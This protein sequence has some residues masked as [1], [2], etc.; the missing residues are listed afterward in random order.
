MVDAESLE[1]VVHKAKT[2]GEPD[3]YTEGF[4]RLIKKDWDF[5]K[6]KRAE[7]EEQAELEEEGCPP[8]DD[9]DDPDNP[10]FRS[11][12]GCE[13]RDVGWMKVAYTQVMVFFYGDRLSD[14]HHWGREY[15]RPPEIV[16]G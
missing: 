15:R 6:E 16:R 14:W 9:L 12:E 4:V 3:P 13:I 11:V 5:E 8:I 1:S 2:P 10:R 7:E